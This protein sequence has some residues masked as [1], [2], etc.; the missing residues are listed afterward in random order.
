MPGIFAF[1]EARDGEIRKVAHESVTAARL[2]ADG[3]GTEVHAVVLGGPGVAQ[4]AP[5]APTPST[6]PRATPSRAT[7]RRASPRSSPAS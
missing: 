2:L 3:L 5:T 1:A 7:R 6:S 4:A